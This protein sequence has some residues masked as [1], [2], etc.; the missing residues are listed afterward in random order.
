MFVQ[1]ALMSQRRENPLPGQSAGF[2]GPE[3]FSNV[4]GVGPNPVIEAMAR[5]TEIALAQ[6]AELQKISGSTQA[7]PTDFTKTS[8]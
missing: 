8:K 6:L 2:K 5:Q 1:T 4:I 3:G 7:V